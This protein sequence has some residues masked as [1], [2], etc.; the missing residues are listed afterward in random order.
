[1]NL[2]YLFSKILLGDIWWFLI[3]K[4]PSNVFYFF[5]FERC[6]RCKKRLVRPYYNYEYFCKECERKCKDEQ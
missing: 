2:K 5:Y 3:T 1:M 4:L 6:T